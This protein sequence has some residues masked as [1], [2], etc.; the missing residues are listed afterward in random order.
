MSPAE[1][2]SLPRAQA[3]AEGLLVPVAPWIRKSLGLPLPVRFTA[4][5]W[6]ALVAYEG[7]H[8]GR[9]DPRAF[10]RRMERV[11]SILKEPI[12]TLGLEPFRTHKMHV[13]LP[14][15]IG[16]IRPRPKNGLSMRIVL[17]VDEEGQET[18]TILSQYEELPT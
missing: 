12:S 6:E 2:L 15:W 16:P 4:T 1:I 3:F 14:N 7:P 9:P 17:T 5:A 11:L 8:G 18:L 10:D 13:F